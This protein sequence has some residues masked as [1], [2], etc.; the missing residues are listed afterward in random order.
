[1]NYIDKPGD[2][3]EVLKHVH[4]ESQ[5]WSEWYNSNSKPRFT[6]TRQLIIIETNE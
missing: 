1:M 5:K 3:V 4:T 2:T 6:R